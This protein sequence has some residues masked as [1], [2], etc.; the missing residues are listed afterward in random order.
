MEHCV[1]Q[2]IEFSRSMGQDFRNPDYKEGNPLE[3]MYVGQRIKY[4]ITKNKVGGKE[5]ATA[6]VDYY[7][8]EGLDIYGNTLSLAEH[9]GLLQGTSWKSLINP[10]T[11]EVI[12]KFQGSAKW[13]DALHS[14]ERL[15]S[16]LYLMVTLAAR[17]TPAEEMMEIVKQEVGDFEPG[18]EASEPSE[19]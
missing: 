13:K 2:M 6:S 3:S 8:D 7:Y 9:M 1:A 4:K 5:G 17:Q 12:A 11:G 16:M 18:A 19:D 14:D 15:W 10:A